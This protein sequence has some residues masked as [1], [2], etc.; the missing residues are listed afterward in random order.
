MTNRPNTLEIDGHRLWS[1]LEASGQ[2]G[3]GRAGGLS[4]LALDASD[5]IM[6]DTFVTWCRDAG[7]IVSVD[8]V[9][10]IFARRDGQDD[11]LAPVMIGSH[12][13]TQVAGG[14]YD[15]I[16][17]VLAGLE[18]LRTLNDR[19][20]ETR[21]PIEVVCWSNE[22][23]ARFQPPMLASG[24]FAG[25]H[26]VEWV[27]DRTDDDGVRY[28][29]ALKEIGYDGDAP[30]GGRSVDSYYE[31]HIE[32]GPVLERDD[33]PLGI[34]TG[35][36]PT[37]GM[38]VDVHGETAHSGPTPM[39]KRRNALIGASMLAVRV[40]E[41]G[42]SFAHEDGKA[43]V[44]RMIAWPN[45]SGILPDYAQISLDVRHPTKAGADAMLR[46]VMTAIPECAERARVDIEIAQL[47][48]FGA[49]VFDADLIDGTK[50]AAKESGVG[51]VELMSQAGH[52]AYNMTRIAPTALLFTPCQD[53]VSHNEGEH[54]E[55]D[56]TI[57]GVNV[58]LAAVVERAN[59]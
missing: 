35:G 46:A 9:G 14:R 18:I 2:I 20:I 39:E 27:L 25:V 59:R 3:P 30:V 52:D 42:W 4:R 16:L 11:T 41:V 8:G 54:I 7:L 17:G 51:M 1:T 12:L 55:A 56:Y 24:A 29:D 26:A 6:R 40:N 28:G 5:K 38:H 47:W 33:V 50:Q 10:N 15:G 13:D 57:P 45:K 21:R 36:Y 22:E 53:G 32:Q 58:L 23:G 48:E 31:L 43:S 37:H 19:D 34:V 44:P 49:E